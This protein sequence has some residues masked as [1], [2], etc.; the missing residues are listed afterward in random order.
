MAVRDTKRMFLQNLLVFHVKM[1]TKYQTQPL[2]RK[3]N[4]LITMSHFV[5]KVVI[6]SYVV[7]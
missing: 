4:A 3:K 7:L 6:Y 1:L 5:A 2:E